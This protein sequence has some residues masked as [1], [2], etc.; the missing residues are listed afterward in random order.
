MC[1]LRGVYKELNSQSRSQRERSF[2]LV[3]DI[4]FSVRDRD[5]MESALPERVLHIPLH[6]FSQ[7]VPSICTVRRLVETAGRGSRLVLHLERILN[8]L[9]R[10]DMETSMDK[11][12]YLYKEPCNKYTVWFESEPCN[13]Y[14]VWFESED[15]FTSLKR[16]E[17]SKEE[18]EEESEDEEDEFLNH[19]PWFFEDNLDDDGIMV[20][21]WDGD[22][23]E[24]RVGWKSLPIKSEKE[25]DGDKEDDLESASKDSDRWD[26]MR[27]SE[28]EEEEEE[29]DLHSMFRESSES[30][31]QSEEEEEESEERGSEEES[32]SASEDSA[33]SIQY[34]TVQEE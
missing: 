32:E 7:R 29:E 1:L 30:F 15:A 4:K 31:R 3:R 23:W 6:V 24:R 21:I 8:E 22:G 2:S 9:V 34:A 12:L 25:P 27:Q 28:E 11:Q 20:M 26:R 13:K 17:K 14:T 33:Y 10:V 18:S 16:R 19:P 5:R